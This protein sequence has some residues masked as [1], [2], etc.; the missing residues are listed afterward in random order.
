M[1][2]AASPGLYVDGAVRLLPVGWRGRAR[3][4]LD[5]LGGALRSWFVGQAIDMAVVGGLSLAGVVILG[6]PLAPLLAGIA[7]LCNFVPYV[8]A[9]GGAVPAVLVALGQ[10][11]DQALWVAGLF[12][13]VQALEGNVIAP[14]VQART[15]NLPPALTILSQTVFGALFGAMGLILAT[16]LLAAGMVA[17]RMVYVED[18]LEGEADPAGG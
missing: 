9:I 4:V 16:P 17:V 5:A 13:V 7:A 14:L 11:P 8:G 18:V 10:G 1:Y 3:E 6:V 2:F 12:A 15:V